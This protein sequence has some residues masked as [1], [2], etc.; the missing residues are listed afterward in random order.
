MEIHET[1]ESLAVETIGYLARIVSIRNVDKNGPYVI[2]FLLIVL[3]PVVIAASIY[4]LFGRIVFYVTPIK[5]QTASFL[6]V[7]PRFLTLIFVS[8]DLRKSI[9]L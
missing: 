5:K 3:A 4:I 7:P 1:N 2:S 9:S 6:W 8:C